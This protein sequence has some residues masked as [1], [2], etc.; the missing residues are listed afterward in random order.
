MIRQTDLLKLNKKQ[1]ITYLGY[2][3]R[4]ATSLTDETITFLCS[5][6]LFDE[7]LKLRL[8]MGRDWY[9]S[10][11]RYR[12]DDARREPDYSIYAR[13]EY[14]VEAWSCWQSYSRMYVKA[15]AK[16]NALFEQSVFDALSERPVIVDLGNGLGFTS[17][18]LKQLAPQASVI[19]TNVSPSLQYD[20]ANA[21][22]NTYDFT[23]TSDLQSISK[24]VDL[25][26]ASE[27]FEHF[28]KPIDHLNEVIE[29]LNPKF[30]ALANAFNTQAIGHFT[31]YAVEDFYNEE[32]DGRTVSNLFNKRLRQ[33]GYKMIDTKIWNQRPVIW[34]KQSTDNG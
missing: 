28:E 30:L 25:V 15:L 1:S 32:T 16:P 18:A 29:T 26:F 19:A 5:H 3:L 17:V 2:V 6:L 7:G 22:S 23:M 31:H 33:H 21:L 8:Q 14:L 24:P 9:D 10:I 27:Y 4:E 11:R 12:I 20:I 34:Q 13:D